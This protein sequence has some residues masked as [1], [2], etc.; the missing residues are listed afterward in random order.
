MKELDGFLYT[1]HNPDL[2]ITKLEVT[3]VIFRFFKMDI[4]LASELFLIMCFSLRWE[5]LFSL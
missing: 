3:V 5:K 1:Y 4:C 2:Y